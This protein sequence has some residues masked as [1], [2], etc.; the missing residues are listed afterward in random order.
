MKPFAMYIFE[1]EHVLTK[2]DLAHMWQNLPPDIGMDTY[3]RN[4]E[5]TMESE[6]V[7]SHELNTEF[8]LLSGE[9]N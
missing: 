2:Q 3:Y 1:F 7:V 9:F 5:D 6:S 8:D 4:E